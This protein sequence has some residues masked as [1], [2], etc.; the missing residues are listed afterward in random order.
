VQVGDEDVVV[1]CWRVQV[2][3]VPLFLLDTDRPENN[4]VSRWIS[5]RL[6]DS[7]EVTR[8][9][10]YVVLGSG[11][12]KMLRAFGIDPG[13]IHMNEGHAAFAALEAAAQA[14]DGRS[15]TRI[16]EVRGR[17][18]FTTH[19]PVPAGNDTYPADRSRGRSGRCA[20][21]AGTDVEHV[22]RLGRTHPDDPNEPFGVTQFALRTSRAANGVSERHGG[23]SR[24]MW[25][26]LWPDRS[27]D[28]VPIGT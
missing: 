13:V 25:Q 7:D 17:T 18:V 23:V 1:Q 19:T 11:G 9:S 5:E 4:R 15:R 24:G 27:V 21:S 28:D 10:Q 8:L 14:G 20:A 16:A 26:G 3:R 12:V 22:L 2:G 6:Y